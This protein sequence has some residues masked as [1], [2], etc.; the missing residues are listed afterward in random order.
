[1]DASFIYL[2]SSHHIQYDTFSTSLTIHCHK[3]GHRN[4][5]GHKKEQS[6]SCTN[7]GAIL[8]ASFGS[9]YCLEDIPFSS[10]N[11]GAILGAPIG[12]LY[13]LDNIVLSISIQTSQDH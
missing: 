6:Y 9:S 11:V 7:V 8:G 5:Y 4:E 10:T 13:C 2:V 12:S 3:K 1:M